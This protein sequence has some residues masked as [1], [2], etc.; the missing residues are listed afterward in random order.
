MSPVTSAKRNLLI[1]E[2]RRLEAARLLREGMRKSEVARVLEVSPMSVTRWAATLEQAGRHG[3]RRAARL[4]RRSKLDKDNLRDLK[5][6]LAQR[7]PDGQEWTLPLIAEHIRSR[8]QVDYH[9]GH[10]WRLLKKLRLPVARRRGRPA[11]RVPDPV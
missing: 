2:K 5:R 6:D 1:L 7:R 4:G 10:V 9:P 11:R 8:F 3:L